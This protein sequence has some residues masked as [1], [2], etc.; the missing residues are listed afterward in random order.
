M[1]RNNLR[2]LLIDMTW[3]TSTSKD[4]GI[5]IYLSA[6]LTKFFRWD[7]HVPIWFLPGKIS[8][9]KKANFY[10]TYRYGEIA[11]EI[12]K[13]SD[14]ITCSSGNKIQYTKIDYA[15]CGSP[16]ERP[17]SLL[18]EVDFLSQLQI[19]L[20]IVIHDL[21]PIQFKKQ[22]LRKWTEKDQ[23]TY[24]NQLDKLHKV[25]H[26]FT[27]GSKAKQDVVQ[28][29]PLL[30]QRVSII[31]FAEKTRW[32]DIPND[33]KDLPKPVVGPYVVTISGG[34]WRKN[35]AGTLLYFSIR[36]P[37][38]Y[39]LVVICKLGKIESIKF[40][41]K[42]AELGIFRRVV[43]TGEISESLKWKY[44]MDAS[45]LISLSF[46]EGLN[47]PVLEAK[48]AGVPSIVLSDLQKKY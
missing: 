1:I 11:S 29:F 40:R 2:Y 3:W 19:P 45:A 15:F 25:E 21:L 30:H 14:S 22:I 8:E 5:G 18:T 7:K 17:W 43:W 37:K 20:K 24:L 39:K 26:I 42:A 4:R 13:S 23:N 44:I 47:L 46:G 34:E 41:L 36:F 31:P 38:N 33:V 32:F 6:L 16:F 27:T 48:Y 12:S 9:F 10:S 35:L 28:Y